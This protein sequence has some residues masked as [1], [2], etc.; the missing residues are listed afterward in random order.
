MALRIV[1]LLLVLVSTLTAYSQT[2]G[3]DRS[4]RLWAEVQNSPPAITLRW[5]PHS[6]TNGF[7]IYRKLKGGTSWGS[8]IASLGSTSLHYTDN[9]AQIG[10]S[11]EYKV[12]RSTSNLGMGYGYINAGIEVPMVENRGTMILVVDDLF[13]GPLATQ[14][15]RLEADL[16]GEGWK[17]MRHDVS[18]NAPVT[19][20]KNLIVSSYNTDPLNTKAV[21]LVGHVPVPYSGNLAPDGHGEHYGAWPADVY[22]GDVN[23]AWT[24]NSVWSTGAA[25]PR[26]HNVPGDG[27]F[28]QTTIP[29]QVELAVGR[30]DMYDLPVFSGQSETQLLGNYLNKLSN[31]KNKVFT[32]QFRGLVDDNFNGY[33]DAFS[34]NAWRG[35]APLVHPDNVVAQDYFGTLS[36]QSYLWSYGCG[37]GWF[38]GANGVGESQMFNSNSVQ[39]VFT[40]LFGSYF[41]DWDNQNNFLRTA[42]GSGTTLTNIWMGYPNW[43][44]HH[45]GLGETIGHGTVLSQ[46]NANG[47][48]EP[49]NWQ[50]GRVHMALMGD[51]TLR[52]HIVAPPTNLTAIQSTASSVLI[53][54]TASAEPVLGYHVYRWS[55]TG[56]T[57][58]R[59]TT[60]AVTGTSYLHASA[61][62]S[63][64]ARYMVRALKLE[65]GYSGSFYN[66]SIGK[67]VELGGGTGDPVDCAGTVNGNA[68]P[69]TPCNDGN[70][71]TFNDTWSAN[72]ECI[73][74]PVLCDDGNP[75]TTND[76]VNG[77]CVFTPITDTDGDGVCDTMDGC[78][79]DPLKYSPGQ[80]GCGAP[81]P[82]TTCDDGDPLTFGDIVGPDCQCA[83]TPVDCFGMPG[84]SA[85]PGSA[86]D[87]GDPATGND[88][89]T[90]DCTC[91]GQPYDC[92]GIPGGTNLPG[93]PCNDGDPLT[94]ADQWNFNCVCEGVPADCLGVPNGTA[95][96]GT[97]CND[98]DPTTGN[99]TWNAFCQCIGLPIDCNGVP[100]G[101]AVID[102]CGVCG[103]Q[104]DCVDVSICIPLVQ[105]D[106][107]NPDGE[108]SENGNVYLDAGGLDLVRDSEPAA[109][110]GDQRTA[111]FFQDVQIPQGAIIVEAYVQF[112]SRSTD[113]LDPCIVQ[114]A[115]QD[116]D[117]CEP[118]H[119]QPFNIS[120]RP[121]TP[122]ITWQPPIWD[123]INAAGAAQRTPNL[124]SA[125]QSV[126]GRAG[127][128]AGNNMVVVVQG[129]GRRVSWSFDQ[130]PTRAPKIC[131]SYAFPPPS[132]CA[133][134]PGG[135]ALPGS[136]CDDGNFLTQDETWTVDCA[137][138]GDLYDCAGELNGS[139]LP[140]TPCDDGDPATGDDTWTVD[141]ECEGAVIDC[142]GVIGGNALPG[143]SCDDG[144][145]STGN[146][147]WSDQCTCAGLPIDCMG[148]PGGSAWPGAACN[149]GDPATGNDLW[150]NDC[151]CAGQPLD[152][153]LVPGGTALPGTPCD[154]GDPDTGDDHWTSDCNCIGEPYDCAGV[155]GG[156][157]WPGAP[158]DDGD[159][160]TGDD[161][162][163]KDCECIGQAIDCNGVAGGTAFIDPCG[164]CVGGTTGQMPAPDTDQ[165]GMVDCIDNCPGYSNPAQLDMDEDGVGDLCDN[166]PW[167]F[168]P[169]QI[170]SNGNNTGD[171][172]EENAITEMEGIPFLAVQ[173]NP[174]TG[175]IRFNT[176]LRDA[177]E[178]LIFDPLGAR[179]KVMPF[180]TTIDLGHIA[181]GT[182][183]LIVRDR[184]GNMLGRV[185][186]VRL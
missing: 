91:A 131:I 146:D 14:L 166:C 97:P 67:I 76:C 78:P 49:T 16:E 140:G 83:G 158:C 99:D 120:S 88:V 100:G 130:S 170:D 74:T 182:Y 147:Q 167:T 43:Y 177:E 63:G 72:C 136:P 133:G 27:K 12:V 139:M 82:W 138:E 65:N 148:V 8:P 163:S 149:D 104:N 102:A 109:W 29:S 64:N 160:D 159:P 151:E 22:Y 105:Q 11:Y 26:N 25:W 143:T 52:M 121:L 95:L 108:E 57:W 13:S 54:W 164:N 153:E 56:Q 124:A 176:D 32:A 113:N 129:T 132:D 55:A 31:W 141:C 180:A 155:P 154:D 10:V 51:P 68:M 150:N 7:V 40:F 186:V 62:S 145:P 79:F 53:N 168:N 111:L 30:V 48:Y 69:G 71:C 106:I 126:V 1:T 107:L 98:G 171:A 134:V 175:E 174:T 173:P 45:M 119:W 112:T 125:V 178:I 33:A 114:I 128:Q 94:V 137:C 61:S 36:S 142:M 116:A 3:H 87:D 44:L 179:V 2:L 162:W 75:C 90:A 39:A 161:S 96:P 34:Q 117:D 93:S 38:T 92:L 15:S 47:H 81:E 59:L 184:S 24:D 89:W 169:D 50:A 66:L 80:C 144:D 20:V 70:A 21:F 17:V 122:A 152:C 101:S 23:G 58:Q 84:G 156:T 19:S 42:L 165:D 37:G 85:M 9:S 115:L 183:L 73:G 77:A 181:S 110:R 127:W 185:R 60:Q 4:V 86:C 41:G 28:D 118:L 123:Q 18:R 5:A 103:G 135:S 157:A 172:C 6:N 35:F 46:N